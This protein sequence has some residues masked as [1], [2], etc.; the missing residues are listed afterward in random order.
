MARRTVRA[1]LAGLALAAIGIGGA[2]AQGAPKLVG[3]FGDWGVYVDTSGSG[4]I[5]YALS[6]PKSRLPSGLKRDPAYFFI[7][8]RTAEN[9]K[10][11]VSVVM[12]FP[13]KE[14]TDATLTIGPANFELYTRGTGAWVRNVAEETRLVDAMRKGRDVVVKSTSLR[15]NVTTDAYSLSGVSAAVDR[16]AQECR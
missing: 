7:S 12:G 1:A 16:A 9:V 11:E 8:T 13:L 5:C 3:Q 14:G 2:T 4:K 10:G 6:Q 15:G